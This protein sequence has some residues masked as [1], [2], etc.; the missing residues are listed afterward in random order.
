[1]KHIKTHKIRP[2]FV[3]PGDTINLHYSFEEPEG[4]YNQRY[5]TMDTFEEPMKIDTLMVY[6]TEE[7]TYGLK[8]EGRVLIM[9]EDDG[10]YVDL[11]ISEGRKYLS[12]GRLQK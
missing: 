9:G 12:N 2:V 4:T 10:T 5:L 1:M 11:P 7:N 6:R 3:K 8:G